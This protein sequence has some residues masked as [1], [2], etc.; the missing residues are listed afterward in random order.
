M[1]AF[2]DSEETLQ[3]S[4]TSS[5]SSVLSNDQPLSLVVSRRKNRGEEHG[6]PPVRH[7]KKFLKVSQYRKEVVP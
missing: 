4:P 2:A 1:C 5:V 6:P 7:W 3:V